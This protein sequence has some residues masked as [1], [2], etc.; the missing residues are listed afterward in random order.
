V[1]ASETL[2]SLQGVVG[3]SAL[4]VRPLA[5][6]ASLRNMERQHA[7]TNGAFAPRD[8][9]DDPF[10]NLPLLR[11]RFDQ[12]AGSDDEADYPQPSSNSFAE[13]ALGASNL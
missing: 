5:V 2:S 3:V 12:R 8:G 13:Y 7:G 6:V 9:T 10:A 4:N 11:G 1:F